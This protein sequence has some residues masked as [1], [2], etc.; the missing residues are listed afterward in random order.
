MQKGIEDRKQS[1]ESRPQPIV[2]TI[3]ETLDEITV[4]YVLIED[5]LYKFKTIFE[6]VD[7]CFKII[8]GLK[9]RYPDQ[10]KHV[11]IFLQKVIF[12]IETKEQEYISINALISDLKNY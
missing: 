9:M 4:S 3:G 5:I 11:W 7:I 6:A 10:S 1:D 2:I 12:N 8:H